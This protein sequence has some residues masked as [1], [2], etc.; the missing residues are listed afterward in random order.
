MN[1]YILKNLREHLSIIEDAVITNSYTIQLIVSRMVDTYKLGGKF[2][3]FGNGGSA[4][5]AQHMAAE[6]TGRLNLERPAIP[7]VAL[8]TDSSAITAIANDYGYEEVFKRQLEALIG[9]NDMIFA[10]STS[11]NSKNVLKAVQKTTHH[12]TVSLTGGDGG[13]L[14]DQTTFNLNVAKAK[15]SSQTQECHI[16]LIHLLIDLFDRQVFGNKL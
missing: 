1:K 6:F 12:Y 8:T 13:K 9:D 15:N 3:I 11:G 5:D 10:I 14:K 16:H 2:I 7:A 4:A